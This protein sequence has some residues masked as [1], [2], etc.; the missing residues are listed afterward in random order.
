[1]TQNSPTLEVIKQRKSVRK[2]TDKPI[3]DA[4][5]DA[6][7]N[8]ALQAP[9][10]GAMS[11][12]SIIEVS[13]PETKKIL[14]ERCDN[15]PFIAEAPLVLLFT[16]DYQRWM[17]YYSYA[18]A[19][20]KCPE[21]DRQP[22]TPEEGDFLLACLDTIAAAQNAVIAAESLGIG[23]CYIGDILEHYEENCQTFALP[24]YTA[25]L[26]LLCF[27]YP[28]RSQIDRPRTPHFSREYIVHK[29]VYRRFLPEEL[30]QMQPEGL[31]MS[32]SGPYGKLSYPQRNY[33]RKFTAEFSIEMSRSVRKIL[34]NWRRD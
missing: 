20:S 29:D 7:I 16:A 34:E 14:A 30:A 28:D 9:T 22:R 1:M 25:P 19:E 10:A 24:R 13:N 32:A 3:D 11:L 23:S 21:F 2:Y 27:G 12:Y 6:I 15:Q 17:D 8:A 18:D 5:K 33:I 26:A 4:C 31:I